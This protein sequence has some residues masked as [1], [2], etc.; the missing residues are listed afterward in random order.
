MVRETFGILKFDHLK[1][2]CKKP[3]L[4]LA[5]NCVQYPHTIPFLKKKTHSL[6][7]LSQRYAVVGCNIPKTTNLEKLGTIHNWALLLDFL[8]L[9]SCMRL[10]SG[11][12]PRNVNAVEDLIA[13]SETNTKHKTQSTSKN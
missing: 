2:N 13:S 10:F 11:I 4:I 12:S 5:I 8:A 1:V 7:K 9:L 3:G 6:L